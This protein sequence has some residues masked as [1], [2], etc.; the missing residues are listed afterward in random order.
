MES[1]IEMEQGYISPKIQLWE[2][3]IAGME[4]K[5]K[6]RITTRELGD[7]KRMWLLGSFDIDWNPIASLPRCD[8]KANNILSYRVSDKWVRW[9]R[10]WCNLWD[11][12]CWWSISCR[13]WTRR[14][15]SHKN[16]LRGRGWWG[17][18][19]I[20]RLIH[21]LEM[22]LWF[23]R[24]DTLQGLTVMVAVMRSMVVFRVWIW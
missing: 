4:G 8:H 10:R 11:G 19:G 15:M 21:C 3:Q 23:Q 22:G 16:G 13:C 1:W 6:G 18:Y 2:K 12:R 9:S 14:L 24:A 5:G 20:W 7:W 17:R